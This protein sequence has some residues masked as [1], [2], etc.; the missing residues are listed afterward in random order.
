MALRSGLRRI[1]LLTALMLGPSALE[2]QRSVRIRWPLIDWLV[3]GDSGRPLM[4]MMSPNRF[5]RHNP[6][7]PGVGWDLFDPAEAVQW[8][9]AV[10]RGLESDTAGAI[11][12]VLWS[13]TGDRILGIAVDSRAAQ[14]ER[15]VVVLTDSTRSTGY[16]S[17]ASLQDLQA[18]L[19]GLHAMAAWTLRPDCL[20][21]PRR[22]GESSSCAAEGQYLHQ[23][24]LDVEPKYLGFKGPSIAGRDLEGES[25][26]VWIELLV[27]SQGRVDRRATCIL[28][29]DG[30]RLSQT[31]LD[32][33]HHGQFK[34]G[35]RAGQPVTALWVLPIIHRPAP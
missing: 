12:P 16:R 28:L 2:S 31:A 19:D 11:G 20:A 17:A 33:I 3:R 6:A 18:L 21:P 22:E 27:D 4:L 13:I 35:E 30:A 26:S 14:S 7:A 1:A 15:L 23:A 10:R 25:G 29:T 9:A 5:G 24:R 34:P 32:F 8:T